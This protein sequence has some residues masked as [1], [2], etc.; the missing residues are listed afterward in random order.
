MPSPVA[1]LLPHSVTTESTMY[2]LAHPSWIVNLMLVALCL[3]R[4]YAHSQG[5]DCQRA[6]STER[7]ICEI[8]NVGVSRT[9][10]CP[11]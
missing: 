11:S 8:S 5:F 3:Y 2:R 9:P 1:L 4:G 7:S 6:L 10:I